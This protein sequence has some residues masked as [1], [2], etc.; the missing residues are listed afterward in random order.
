MT[1]ELTL[2]ERRQL[3]TDLNIKY[4]LS[5]SGE[6]VLID[7]GPFRIV[8]A[9]D[10]PFLTSISSNSIH[11]DTIQNVRA[12]MGRIEAAIKRLV[13]EK[14]R[15]NPPFGWATGPSAVPDCLHVNNGSAFLTLPLRNRATARAEIL[16]VLDWYVEQGE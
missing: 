8:W 9:A 10:G 6:N 11:L 5:A 7:F 13:E 12:T 3:C 14:R 1:M 2:Q 4:A 16:K 15:K